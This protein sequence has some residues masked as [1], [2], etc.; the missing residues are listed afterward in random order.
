MSFFRR[1]DVVS[2]F[3]EYKGIMY[4]SLTEARFAALFISLNLSFEYEPRRFDVTGGPYWP[5]FYLPDSDTWIE[6]KGR[7]STGDEELRCCQLCNIVKTRV[8]MLEGVPK[9]GYDPDLNRHVHMGFLTRLVDQSG[10]DEMTPLGGGMIPLLWATRQ[11]SAEST[12]EQ[13]N[14]L[15]DR[16]N[17][18]DFDERHGLVTAG[19]AIEQALQNSLRWT[20]LTK[21]FSSTSL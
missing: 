9:I 4:R 19:E 1:Q 7:V 15:L 17:K 8:L 18:A 5:D 11:I 14:E 6:V 16:S 2:H 21:S 13:I 3:T 20:P 12:H 10:C